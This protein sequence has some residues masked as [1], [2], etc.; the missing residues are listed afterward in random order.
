[1]PGR[2]RI[3][4]IELVALEPRARLVLVEAA[5]GVEAERRERFLDARVMEGWRAAGIAAL[6]CTEEG[7]VQYSSYFVLTRLRSVTR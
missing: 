5:P 6:L 2:R 3:L 7:D 4:R 1:M